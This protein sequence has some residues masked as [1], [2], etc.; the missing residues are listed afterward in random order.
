MTIQ[1][2]IRAV[3]AYRKYSDDWRDRVLYL[4]HHTVGELVYRI[5]CV[6]GLHRLG[7]RFYWYT[8]PASKKFHWAWMQNQTEW[9]EQDVSE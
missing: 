6:V 8:D 3:T 5:C 7:A 4:I 1:E 9:I 2:R